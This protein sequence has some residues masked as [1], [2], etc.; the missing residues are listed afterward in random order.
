[1]RY[2]CFHSSRRARQGSLPNK[3][4]KSTSYGLRRA[5]SVCFH[6]RGVQE[7][8]FHA[9]RRHE[10]QFSINSEYRI[11][12]VFIV[13]QMKP[14]YYNML[15]FTINV[16]RQIYFT[17]LQSRYR[18]IVLIQSHY[19]HIMLTG[20]GWLNNVASPRSKAFTRTHIGN[21]RI[22]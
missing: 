5:R 13:N 16:R 22:R 3:K 4:Y 2:A 11:Y 18:Y 20:L 9:R 10:V 15:L 8:R 14:L 21:N 19:R 12:N 7:T 1:M 17:N 6:F